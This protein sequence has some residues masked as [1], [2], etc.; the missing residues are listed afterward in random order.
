MNFAIVEI[1]ERPCADF[2]DEPPPRSW[3]LSSFLE[4][5]RVFTTAEYLREIDKAERNEY[6]AGITGNELDVSFLQNEATLE[7]L[8]VEDDNGEFATTTLPLAEAKQLLLDWQAALEK[9]RSEN[10]D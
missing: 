5:A 4:E 10:P 8:W 2:S 7:S 6:P 3:L 1:N 9:W